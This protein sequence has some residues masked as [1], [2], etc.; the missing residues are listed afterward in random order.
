[1]AG[2]YH[3][4]TVL[5]EDIPFEPVAAYDIDPNRLAYAKQ[6][7]LAAYIVGPLLAII[8]MCIVNKVRKNKEN[9]AFALVPFLSVAAMAMF[10]I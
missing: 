1:M 8:V 5:R 10:M 4:D 6:R 3:V 9:K 7:G 2:G